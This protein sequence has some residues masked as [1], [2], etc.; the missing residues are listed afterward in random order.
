MLCWL[1][2]GTIGVAN[3]GDPDPIDE[4]VATGSPI[5]LPEPGTAGFLRINYAA[6]IGVP[7]I[8][9]QIPSEDGEGT[10]CQ[11]KGQC[12]GGNPIVISSGQ[13]IETQIDFVGPG[14]LPLTIERTYR[15][16][17][18]SGGGTRF[19]NWATNIT[20]R[21]AFFFFRDPYTGP[22]EHFAP[23]TQLNAEIQRSDGTTIN[24]TYE[25]SG[26]EYANGERATLVRGDQGRVVFYAPDG[27]TEFYNENGD[28][29]RIQHPN[30]ES[31]SYKFDTSGRV[32]RVT[33]SNGSELVVYYGASGV[34][35]ITDPGGFDYVYGYSGGRLASVEK[36]ITSSTRATRRYDYN[37]QG[38]LWRIRDENGEG[39][40]HWNY[41]SSGRAY[42]SYHAEL[43]ESFMV[44]FVSDSSNQ[45]IRRTTNSL[46]HQTTYTYERVAGQ[47]KA[48]SIRK[49]SGQGVLGSTQTYNYDSM[50]FLESIVDFSGAETRYV[51]SDFG[52]ILN[53]TIGFGTTDAVSTAY[54]WDDAR[55]SLP[56]KIETTNLRTE[57]E[58]DDY[59]SISQ[60]KQTDL[61]SFSSDNPPRVTSITLTRDDDLRISRRVI[62]GPRS[63]VNDSTTMEYDA[64]GRLSYIQNAKGHRT[65]FEQYDAYGRPQRI[66]SPRGD[67]RDFTFS[68]QGWVLSET[69]VVSGNPRRTDYTYDN[70][71]NIVRVDFPDGTTREFEYDRN[72][73]LI[74]ETDA[75][76]FFVRNEYSKENGLTDRSVMHEYTTTELVITGMSPW[77]EPI[78]GTVTTTQVD[79]LHSVKTPRDGLNRIKWIENAYGD[80]SYNSYADPTPR[81]SQV[82][83]PRGW[84]SNVTYDGARRPKRS[85]DHLGR[86]LEFQYNADG[87][88]R[89]SRDYLGNL[90]IY[91]RNGFGEIERLV[92]PDAGTTE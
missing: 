29:Y 9:G 7:V 36:P 77:G 15:S 4:V 48:K 3:A 33:H 32:N 51:Y 20:T 60:I 75:D 38:K 49:E 11:K 28:L 45:L 30:G 19:A 16:E 57:F 68:P 46:G 24:L 87:E 71:G 25:A 80:R 34:S 17:G 90:T 44:D 26:W 70:V 14:E 67:Y 84:S 5:P 74:R 83:S 53:Q 85:T 64:F 62:D 8:P 22:G 39:Y 50:G 27:N 37:A 86:F 18:L 66:I 21:K 23:G 65:R 2:L 42:H 13:K 40:A 35:R 54:T 81:V 56:K 41:D 92:S 76:G 58:Y 82:T 69:H 55:R 78:V 1:L 79:T 91:E 6:S 10:D 61:S 89:S 43:A 47:W 52:Q 72:Y 88:V 31:L 73:R 59:G 63:G 12:T